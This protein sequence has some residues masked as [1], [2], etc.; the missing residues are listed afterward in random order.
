MNCCSYGTYVL[1][2]MT[3][4]CIHNIVHEAAR[5]HRNNNIIIIML[6]IADSY[7]YRL[8]A[9][10]SVHRALGYANDETV[11]G[12]QTGT[13]NNASHALQLWSCNYYVIACAQQ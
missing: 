8:I 10:W 1:G 9:G 3:N 5:E 4:V 12:Q 6:S 13:F 11:M 2:G 7:V